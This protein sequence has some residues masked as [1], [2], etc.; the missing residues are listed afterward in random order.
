MGVYK[1]PGI[2][3]RDDY[4][5]P[6]KGPNWNTITRCSKISNIFGIEYEP[7][8]TFKVPVGNLSPSKAKKE[9]NNLIKQYAIP[10]GKISYEVNNVNIKLKVIM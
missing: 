7:K 4:W 6:V 9:I 8:K 1:S 5:F 2:Y 10:V 3:T